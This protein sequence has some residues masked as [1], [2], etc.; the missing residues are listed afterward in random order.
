LKAVQVSPKLCTRHE[1]IR[2]SRYP[3]DWKANWA[4]SAQTKAGSGKEAR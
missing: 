3:T 1:R 2:H 4:G